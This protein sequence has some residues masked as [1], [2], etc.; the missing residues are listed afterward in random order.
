MR[1]IHWNQH[2]PGPWHQ[3]DQQ[4]TQPQMVWLGYFSGLP[5]RQRNVHQRVERDEHSDEQLFAHDAVAVA[6]LP[7]Q[8]PSAALN[9]GVRRHLI[10][11]LVVLL[12]LSISAPAQTRL[13][14]SA[15][16]PGTERVQLVPNGDFQF[17]GPPVSGSYPT[18]TGWSRSGDMFAAAGSNTVTLNG[19]VIAQA[20][21]LSG[22]PASG[23][24]Q[25]VTLE[26]AT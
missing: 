2:A 26:P 6:V 20:Q 5:D 4:S 17:Q 21:M 16:R 11:P 8:I 19:G 7:A 13:K 3:P 15:I 12:G 1:S 18:P 23:Y 24:S 25:S 10:I 9:K 22:A 14:L